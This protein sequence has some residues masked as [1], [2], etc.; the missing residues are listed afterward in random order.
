MRQL[1]VGIVGTGLAFERL[2][3]PAY[4]SLGEQYR[5]TALCD[6]DLEAAGAWAR[7]LGVPTERVTAD[8]AELARW[9]DVDVVDIMVPIPVNFRVTQQVAAALA[10]SAKGIICEKPLA[11]TRREAAA[12][13]R[14]P[15]KYGIPILIAENYRYD[16]ENEKIRQMVAERW[17]GDPVY[18]V[19]NRVLDMPEQ[20]RGRGFAATEW[21]Q[22]PDFPGGVILDTGVHDIAALRHIFGPVAEVQAYG[23]PQDDDFAPFAALQAGIRFSGGVIGQYSFFSA[24]G[25][26]QR[27]LVGL[28]IFG[29][30]G[31]IFLEE[32]GCGTINVA[33]ADGRSEQVAYTPG[34]GYRR[35]L[36][37]LYHHLTGAQPLAVPPEIEFGDARTM[38]AIIRSAQRGQRVTLEREPVPVP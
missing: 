24:G 32:E 4:R 30:R 11:A 34:Q 26:P 36:L 13:R 21:R 10:H 12:A 38:L 3:L 35:E 31:M 15:E 14:L 5:I 29:T 19:R 17:V 9:G 7:R 20:M 16:E 23:V 37:N 28:R 25:E 1:G 33:H 2:H 18:L 8:P 22:H 27:P 6:Q